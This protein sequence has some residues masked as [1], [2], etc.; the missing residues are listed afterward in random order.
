MPLVQNK[1]PIKEI[2]DGIIILKNNSLRAILKCSSLNFF[3]RSVE[4]Q[5]A[6]TLKYQEFINSLDFPIQVLILSRRLNLEKYLDT[7]EEKKKTQENELLRIQISQYTEYIRKLVEI[8][9]LVNK[10][11]Y[12][13]V[14]YNPIVIN[15]QGI[16][17][18]V[19][20]LFKI[21]SSQSNQSSSEKLI[22]E[23]FSNWR[24]QLQ[25]RVEYIAGGISSL[26][27]QVNL[28]KDEETINLFYQLY[29][30]GQEEKII[31]NIK[32]YEE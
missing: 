5:N 10:E 12:V 18:K 32:N 13:I 6:L 27:V 23:K 19:E 31:G 21:K 28:L 26:G 11:F 4:D 24:Y 14:P 30:L 25:T 20:N 15:D 2:R 8:T 22:E 3:L 16:V 29:N 1:V 9:N 17:A 7:L